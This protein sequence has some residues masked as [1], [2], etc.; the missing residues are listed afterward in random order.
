MYKEK[1]NLKPAYNSAFFDAHFDF[2]KKKILAVFYKLWMQNEWKAAHFQTFT[3]SK[4]QIFA[5]IYHSP[6]DSHKVWN[7]EA[8]QNPK[9]SV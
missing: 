5:N 3:K 2:P 4:K 9:V 6:F 1:T 8:P 7:F